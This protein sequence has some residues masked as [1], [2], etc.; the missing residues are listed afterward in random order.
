MFFLKTWLDAMLWNV[1]GKTALQYAIFFAVEKLGG[2][3]VGHSPA[4]YSKLL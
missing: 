2:N 4:M 1:I 3:N